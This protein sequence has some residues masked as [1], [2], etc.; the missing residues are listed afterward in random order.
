MDKLEQI[1]KYISG[2][3]DFVIKKQLAV[4][5]N[6]SLIGKIAFYQIEENVYEEILDEIKRIKN[7]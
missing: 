3:R 7:S 6:P 1:E 4:M 5:D 2:C